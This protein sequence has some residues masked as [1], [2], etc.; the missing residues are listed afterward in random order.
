MIFFKSWCLMNDAVDI[1]KYFTVRLL[2][3]FNT[4]EIDSFKFINNTEPCFPLSR[5]TTSS[6]T[7]IT[8]VGSSFSMVN[9]LVL[10]GAA[11]MAHINF[12]YLV[13][14]KNYAFMTL[15]N[16]KNLIFEW[17]FCT[18]WKCYVFDVW[19]SWFTDIYVYRQIH[20]TWPTWWLWGTQTIKNERIML[21]EILFDAYESLHVN[22][23]IYKM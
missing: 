22:F 17:R 8:L 23:V 21:T 15:W 10:L 5:S 13:Y 19:H 4:T 12:I 9:F 11:P 7:F 1:N 3:L 18:S 2:F 16:L 20:N 14:F 6:E